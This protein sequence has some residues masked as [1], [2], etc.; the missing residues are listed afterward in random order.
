V[1]DLKVLSETLD[2][3]LY[4]FLL[5]ITMSKP[6]VKAAFEKAE[7]SAADVA[8]ALKG[9]DD[10]PRDVLRS[11]YKAIGVIRAQLPYQKE[12]RDELASMCNKLEMVFFLILEGESP[13]DRKPGVPRII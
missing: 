5:P 4:D 9:R 3:D 2:R 1:V 11:I 6:A 10:L 12:G 8:R 7:R 13:D